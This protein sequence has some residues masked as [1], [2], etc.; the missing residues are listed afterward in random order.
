MSSVT[1]FQEI[2]EEYELEVSAWEQA[3]QREYDRSL[4][5]YQ[6]QPEDEEEVVIVRKLPRP[7]ARR[8]LEFLIGAGSL[9]IEAQEAI[10]SLE[11]AIGTGKSRVRVSFPESV[12]QWL[13]GQFEGLRGYL[14]GRYEEQLGAFLD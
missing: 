2:R 9:S 10:A 6:Q 7:L 8:V 1:K 14:N 11:D 12:F 5:I 13:K 3:V 4:K